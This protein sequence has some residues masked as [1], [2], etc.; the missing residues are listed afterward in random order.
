MLTPRRIGEG[1]KMVRALFTVAECLQPAV[2]F[3]DEIDS[4]LSARKA[5]GPLRCQSALDQPIC[6]GSA[7]CRLSR[8]GLATPVLSQAD[9]HRLKAA[10]VVLTLASA[11]CRRARGQPAAEDR[12]LDADGGCGR[13]HCRSPHPARCCHQPP[14]GESCSAG[15]AVQRTSRG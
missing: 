2:I 7:R 14:R 1:E 6:I 5:E 11:P 13:S 10:H 3:I 15:R 8:Q 9:H 4:I 12:D